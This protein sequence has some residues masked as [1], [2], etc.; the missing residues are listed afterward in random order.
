MVD[1][2]MFTYYIQI[3]NVI[4]I[5]ECVILIQTGCNLI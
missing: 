4:L 2:L 3:I 1:I 5:Y